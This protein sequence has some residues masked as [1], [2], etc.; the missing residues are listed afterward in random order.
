VRTR[1][2]QAPDDRLL[3]ALV[4]ERDGDALSLLYSRHGAAV[5]SAALRLLRDTHDAEDVTQ[6]LFVQLPLTLA[7]YDAA[8]GALGPW[9]RRVAVRGA[10]M[11]L[12]SGRRRREVGAADI[13]ALVARPDSMNERIDIDQA[14]AR[15]VVEQRTV[16]LLKE[17]EGYSHRE[18][19]D[20]LGISI[21][22]SEVRLYRARV[23]LRALLG[24]ES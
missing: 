11:K 12:R 7:A 17:V 15:L 1:D 14:L 24:S 3:V 20:L 22:A 8:L 19:A 21:A 18:I 6:E 10:L 5:Y 9:L 4:I 13:A 2:S 23:A 16:F